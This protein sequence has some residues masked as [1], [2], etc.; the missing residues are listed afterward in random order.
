V[1]LV[2]RLAELLVEMRRLQ[3]EPKRLRLVHPRA[4]EPANLLLIE[5]RKLG[6]PGLEVA[7][8]LFVYQGSGRDYT[9]E[10]AGLYES[11]KA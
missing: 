1:Y 3:L 8:P 10:I 4:G 11:R 9:A 5:G 2:E 7:P 6:K